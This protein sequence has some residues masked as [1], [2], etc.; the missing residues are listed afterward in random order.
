MSTDSRWTWDDRLHPNVCRFI[1]EPNGTW[2]AHI[3]NSASDAI[4]GKVLCTCAASAIAKEVLSKQISDEAIYRKA[5]E[6]LELLNQWI[7]SP[8]Q[9]RSDRICDLLYGE[10]QAWCQE[11]DPFGVIWWSL[12]VAMSSVGNFEAGWALE[13]VCSAARKAGF[14]DNSLRHI[15]RLALLSR[16][17]ST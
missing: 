8:S 7:D 6:P 13:T 14:D 12:R 10:N 1:D 5:A 17:K 2:C 4:I 16:L 11:V 15:A 9:E 3:E